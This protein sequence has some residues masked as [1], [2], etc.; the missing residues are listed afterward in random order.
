MSLKNTF[1]KGF[2]LIE[3]IVSL[4]VFSV[5]V[6]TA[7]GAMLVLISTNQQL[8]AEQSVMTNLAFAL[9]TMTR[10]MRTGFNYYCDQRANYAAGGPNNIFE[11]SNDHEAILGDSVNDCANGRTPANHELQGVSFYEGG[12]SLTGNVVGASRILYFFD[13]VNQ[14][15][16]RRV[17]N[18]EA[19][20]IVSSGIVIQNAEFFVT[21]TNNLSVAGD[22][23]QPTITVYIEAQEVDD[24]TAKTY[25]LQTTVTQRTL[26]L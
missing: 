9:D 26:D 21:G 10:E 1:N 12:N 25:Y 22:T 19:Q 5:V 3:M 2:T 13:E 14:T 4:G 8:Q 11:D 7:V 6:T 24:P 16:M 17:G 23:Q 15:I 18:D 20:S